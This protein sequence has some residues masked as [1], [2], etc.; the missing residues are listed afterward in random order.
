MFPYLASKRPGVGYDIQ[1]KIIPYFWHC[2]LSLSLVRCSLSFLHYIFPCFARIMCQIFWGH[3]W[4]EHTWIWNICQVADSL[5]GVD[6]WAQYAF[7]FNF[8]LVGG[9]SLSPHQVQLNIISRKSTRLPS[10]PFSKWDFPGGAFL[11]LYS[12]FSFLTA[13]PPSSN[14]LEFSF[15]KYQPGGTSFF[16]FSAS[17]SSDVKTP[18]N[19]FC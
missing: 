19:I 17:Y 6:L 9:V 8:C 16:F 3:L 4:L 10:T 18:T 1:I 7:N 15:Q 13:P 14:N 12:S 5:Y 11:S 2:G